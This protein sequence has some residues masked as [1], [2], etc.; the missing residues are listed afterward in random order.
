MESYS[1]Q[2]RVREAI[3]GSFKSEM[4]SLNYPEFH[5]KPNTI[6]PLGIWNYTTQHAL[7]MHFIC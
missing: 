7:W 1:E 5:T 2:H 4:Q 3:L 6:Q